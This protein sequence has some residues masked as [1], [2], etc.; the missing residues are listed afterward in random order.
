MKN[1]QFSAG[2][3]FYWSFDFLISTVDKGGERWVL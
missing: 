1:S 3:E 2:R